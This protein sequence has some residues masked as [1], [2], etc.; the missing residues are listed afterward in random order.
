MYDAIMAQPA[1]FR[2]VA[3]RHAGEAARW[4]PVLAGARRLWLVG[5]GSSL[6][7]ARLGAYGLRH[8]AEG[9][10]VQTVAAFDFVLYGPSLSRDDVVVVVSHRGTKL[11]SRQA[12]P[13]ARAAGWATPPLPGEG[14]EKGAPADGS[15]SA[16]AQDQSAGHAVGLTASVAVLWALAVAAGLEAGRA[17]A[18]GSPGERAREAAAAIEESAAAVVGDLAAALAAESAARFVA[19]LCLRARR[20]WLAGGGPG[21]VGA[22]ATGPQIL[23][24]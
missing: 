7:A 22:G 5:T 15:F 2:E 20:I 17:G 11:Y 24:T 12:L 1:A 4:A 14:G 18:P 8:Q 3:V 16:V 23:E 10:D 13:R 19:P 21:G 9:L 6:H